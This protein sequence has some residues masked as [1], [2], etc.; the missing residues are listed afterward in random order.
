MK[1]LKQNFSFEVVGGSYKSWR[2]LIAKHLNKFM[3]E[4]RKAE[5][6]ILKVNQKKTSLEDLFIKSLT[7]TEN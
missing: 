1:H 5:V 3:D 7:E 2:L 6:N 4:L